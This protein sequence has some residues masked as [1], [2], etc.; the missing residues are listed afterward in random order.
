MD[1]DSC[2]EQR[3]DDVGHRETNQIDTLGFSEGFTHV[4]HACSDASSKHYSIPNQRL[5]SS[6]RCHVF[7][8]KKTYTKSFVCIQTPLGTKV[9]VSACSQPLPHEST[10]RANSSPAL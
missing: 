5:G 8:E 10:S 1:V 3:V 9:K 4:C 2:V 6:Q 7:L